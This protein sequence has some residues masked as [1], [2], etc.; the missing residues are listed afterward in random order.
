[1]L[2]PLGLSRV[3]LPGGRFGVDLFFVLCGFLVIALLLQEFGRE[4]RVDLRSFYR[5]RAV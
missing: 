1:M 3:L 5:R 2:V 4:G